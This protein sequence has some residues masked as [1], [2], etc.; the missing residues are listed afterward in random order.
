MFNHDTKAI[1]WFKKYLRYVD[2]LAA[3]QLYLKANFFLEHELSPSDIKDRIL[4]HWGSV[5]GQNFIW[6]NLNYLIYKHKF[7]ALYVSGP[8][9]G[10]P[11]PLANLFADGSMTHFYPHLTRDN[12][13][14]QRFIKMFSW[15]GGFPSHTNPGTPGTILEGGELGYS[16]STSYGAV[17]DNPDLIVAC[18][19]GDGE[20]ETG[21]LAASWHSN[22]FLNP[23]E[24]GAVLP[25]VLVNG[26]KIS[27]PTIIGTM[28]D[29]E[30]RQLFSGY[31][32]QPH[33]LDDLTPGTHHVKEA[34][35]VFELAYQ[36]IRRIQQKARREKKALIRPKWPVIIYKCVKGAGGIKVADNHKIEGNF[37][38]HGIPLTDPKSNLSHFQLVKN[39]LESYKITE[40]IDR[41]GRPKKEVLEFV[42]KLSECM[43]MNKHFIGGNFRKELSLP[44]IFDYEVK[45]IKPGEKFVGNTAVASNYFRD[46][47]KLNPHTFRFMCPDE[48]DSNKFQSLFEVTKR[49]YV[50]PLKKHDEF[51]GPKGRIMEILSEH[52]LQGWLQGYILTGRHGIF[53]TYEAF[54]EIVTSMVDQHAKFIKY[55]AH[56]PFRKPISSL[57][58]I[59]TSVGWRQEH[60]GFSHQNPSFISALL[61]K[62]G[63]F[64]SAYFPPDANSTLVIMEDCLKRTNSINVIAINKTPMPQ[65]LTIEE[66]RKQLKTGIGVWDFLTPKDYQ[67][68][69]VVFV[70]I[71]DVMVQETIAAMCLLR[72]YIPELKLRFV[73]VSELTA[74]GVGDEKHPLTC[75]RCGEMDKYFTKDKPVIFSFHGYPGVITKLISGYGSSARFSVHGYLEEGTTTT[76]FDML[77]LN[78]CSR[79]HFAIEALEKGI[80]Q[81]NS[82]IAQKAKRVIALFKEKLEQHRAYIKKYGK[83]MDE[84]ENWCWYRK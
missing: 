24:S 83:D 81:N 4:G 68:P 79:Y 42:P 32:Y 56:I 54:A 48:T 64:C 59:L 55:S 29:Q 43:G 1:S 80:K 75:E 53:A 72:S 10:A 51:I 66:A 23:A 84:V 41:N 49:A 78:K 11:G 63:K 5:P 2:Y 30:I 70:G 16:L 34:I 40:L 47:I 27:G 39:W 3:A 33:I 58:Y 18:V 38:C 62:H 65:W 25:I 35:E 6:A 20:S 61:E 8:G 13:G 19:V 14:T 71:G 77:V 9:H 21:P 36:E 57:N 46:I 67:S 82:K 74:L 17:L 52:T 12:K 22:K 44:S 50:W 69:D 76:A 7:S 60:N 73:N 15:P 26:Y 31:G 37:R 45:F 28:S